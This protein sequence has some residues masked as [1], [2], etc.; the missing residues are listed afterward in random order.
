[1]RAVFFWATVEFHPKGLLRTAILTS[2]EVGNV[3]MM[4]TSWFQ[5]W[6]CGKRGPSSILVTTQTFWL[7]MAMYQMNW[8]PFMTGLV[9][10]IFCCSIQCTASVH[11]KQSKNPHNTVITFWFTRRYLSPQNPLWSKGPVLFS[12]LLWS[13]AFWCLLVLPVFLTQ[14]LQSLCCTLPLFLQGFTTGQMQMVE[15]NTMMIE[16]REREISQIVRSIQDLNEIFKDLGSLVVDQVTLNLFFK[17]VFDWK[18]GTWWQ[19]LSNCMTSSWF[20]VCCR[21]PGSQ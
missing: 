12:A 11:R 4:Y 19:M 8:M 9:A 2:L 10:D 16:Q 1:M 6:K 20:A 3:P 7:E 18:W 14:S 5:N 15:D 13:W 21:K 17:R